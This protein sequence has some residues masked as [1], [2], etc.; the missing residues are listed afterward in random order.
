M[1]SLSASS[2]RWMISVASLSTSKG[3]CLSE[4]G[5]CRLR[6]TQWIVRG[7]AN[8]IG[9]KLSSLSLLTIEL[10]CTHLRDTSSANI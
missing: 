4:Y 6:I 10:V 7:L 8:L 1:V 2:N 3:P 5:I 9:A